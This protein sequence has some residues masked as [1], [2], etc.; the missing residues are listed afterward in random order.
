M[1][2]KT[3]LAEEIKLGFIYVHIIDLILDTAPNKQ[4]NDFKI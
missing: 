3:E 4:W 1:P 2:A